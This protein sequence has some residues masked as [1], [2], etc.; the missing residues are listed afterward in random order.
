MR[1]VL[2]V[3]CSVVPAVAGQLIL[4]YTI[5]RLNLSME[6]SG[7]VGYYV[8]LF[9]TPLVL[10]GFAMYGLSSIAWLFILSKLPLSL[11]YPLVSMGY[12][13]VVF[14]SW[15]LLHEQV[16]VGRIVG[17]IVICCGVALL[18]RTAPSHEV[19]QAGEPGRPAPAVDAL[20]IGNQS[21]NV[22]VARS[23]GAY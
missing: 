12:V 11:A 23:G 3:L 7:P 20:P 17:V 14:F 22:P 16:G 10:L 15:L 18:A 21:D 2:L 19:S 9:Q 8:R 4:K 1:A 6:T 5:A 13:L